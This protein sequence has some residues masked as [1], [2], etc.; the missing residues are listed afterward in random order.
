MR[1]YS[2][3]IKE[4]TCVRGSHSLQYYQI[5]CVRNIFGSKHHVIKQKLMP[6]C[7][8]LL[9]HC[10]PTSF[11]TRFLKAIHIIII[12]SKRKQHTRSEL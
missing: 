12:G 11:N 9:E 1:F 10:V 7:H 2:V 5:K 6:Q 4:F 8:I 3:N